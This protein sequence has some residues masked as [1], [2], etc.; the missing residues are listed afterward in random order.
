MENAPIR[1]GSNCDRM[2]PWSTQVQT[3]RM[4]L[5]EKSPYNKKRSLN[6]V[7]KWME[8]W[9]IKIAKF[10]RYICHICYDGRHI[11]TLINEKKVL[12]EKQTKQYEKFKGHEKLVSIQRSSYVKMM[13]ELSPSKALVIFDYST[14]NK[15]TI[16]K[17]KIFNCTVVSVND[18]SIL[19]IK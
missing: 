14:F 15:T 10:D 19:I 2:V 13:K 18:N 9:R 3:H 17:M 8:H 7:R 5:K 11:Q 16:F 4:Y 12:N 6:W 1:S